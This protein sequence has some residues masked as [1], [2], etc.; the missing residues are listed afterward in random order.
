MEVIL[1]NESLR[2]KAWKKLISQDPSIQELEKI[3][4]KQVKKYF[5]HAN[6]EIKELVEDET[7]SIKKLERLFEHKKHLEDFLETNTD[8]T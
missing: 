2:E 3:L 7:D 4:E 1:K 5:E 6:N 8:Q